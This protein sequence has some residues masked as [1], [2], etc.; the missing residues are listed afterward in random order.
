MNLFLDH[1]SLRKSARAAFISSITLIIVHG[2][3]AEFS[4]IGLLGLP[5]RFSLQDLQR[6]A[7][8]VQIFYS[9]IFF[10]RAY[11]LNFR[12]HI[13]ELQEKADER[14]KKRSELHGA[15]YRERT[16]PLEIILK[17][18]KAPPEKREEA[19]ELR[20]KQSAFRNAAVEKDTRRITILLYWQIALFFLI[21]II[22]PAITIVAAW[23]SL[24]LECVAAVICASNFP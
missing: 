5:V 1:T 2:C 14:K 11:E 17:D 9:V 10:F 7:L 21:E 23:S 8:F 22:A 19:Q 4:S 16:P 24:W 18:Q 12:H 20:K 3:V 15:K 6:L 13:D